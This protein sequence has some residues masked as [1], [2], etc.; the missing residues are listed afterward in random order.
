MIRTDEQIKKDMV[1]ELYW[2]YRV[3]ASNV[4]AEVS[5]GE[6]TLTGTVPNYAARNAAA[7]DA[8]G[9]D[10]VKGLTNLLTVRF[11]PTFTVPTDAEIKE[12]ADR[13]LSLYEYYFF[14]GNE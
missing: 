3:D 13:L 7:A 11:P 5:A 14:F 10:G 9:I 2:D 1:D 6:V 8:W 12:S 4:K